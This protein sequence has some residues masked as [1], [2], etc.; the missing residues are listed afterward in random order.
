L[1]KTKKIFFFFV[2]FF[3]FLKKGQGGG[4]GARG[5]SAEGQ[6]FFYKVDPVPSRSIC[7]FFFLFP[8]TEATCFASPASHGMVKISSGPPFENS[9]HCPFVN[10]VVVL[11]G[12]RNNT[13]IGSDK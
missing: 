2:F 11:V 13:S 6:D 1:A 3:F 4:A 9:S 5:Q 8:N 7:F 12:V 10:L